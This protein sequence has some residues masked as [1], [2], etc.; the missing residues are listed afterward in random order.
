MN[1]KNKH[2]VN[3]DFDSLLEFKSENDELKH[4][5]Y[6]LMFKFL[7]EIQ[8]VTDY[9]IHKKDL[10]KAIDSSRSFVSQ[11]FSGDKLANLITLAKLQKAYNLTFEIKANLNNADSLHNFLYTTNQRI[12]YGGIVVQNELVKSSLKDN[13][14]SAKQPNLAA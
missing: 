6:M 12:N 1:L 8:R 5:A 11:L 3:E 13:I 10:A 9:T 2:T 7:S 4:E 14:T